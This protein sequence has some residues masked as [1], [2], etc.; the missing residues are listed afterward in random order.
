MDKMN[1]KENN[2]VIDKLIVLYKKHK[3]IIMYVIFGGFTTVVSLATY[4]IFGSLLHFSGL[5]S[6]IISWIAS[7]TFAFVTN[8]LFVFD[9]KDTSLKKIV[10]EALSFYGCRLF[11]GAVET[12]FIWLTVDIL[13]FNSMLMK[14]IVS[15]F[16][17]IT[18]YFFSKIFVFKKTENKTGK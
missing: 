3:E 11:S 15:V 7:V 9:S 12:F 8:K 17:V 14:L 5:V 4:W 1:K 16:V 2:K 6:N 10:A 18:N 13:S